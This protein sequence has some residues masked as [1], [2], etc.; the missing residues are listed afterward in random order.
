VSFYVIESD[1][2]FHDA[3]FLRECGPLVFDPYVTRQWIRR[4]AAAAPARVPVVS[5]PAGEFV[6]TPC[7]ERPPAPVK[8]GTTVFG[9]D[10]MVSEN[11][12]APRLAT[13]AFEIS[14]YPV[15]VAEYARCVE[16]GACVHVLE[17]N[18]IAEIASN[19]CN[20]GREGR[21]RHPMNCV[22]WAEATEY[23]SAIGGR[24]PTDTEW[25]KAASVRSSAWPARHL[26]DLRVLIDRTSVIGQMP[27]LASPYGVDDA[28]WHVEEWTASPM[29]PRRRGTTA[30]DYIEAPDRYRTVRTYRGGREPSIRRIAP[31][32]QK[33]D[34][35]GFRCVFPPTR[36]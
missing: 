4:T 11:A 8:E 30:A 13:D 35:L 28:G 7:E 1:G 34:G 33:R 24:L 10:C 6:A 3:S 27:E 25:D 14:R 21:E 20:W 23:C 18:R 36:G 12:P 29:E 31:T 22:D 15:T 16:R 17:E 26:G 9:S 5:V 19:E 2:H 32:D